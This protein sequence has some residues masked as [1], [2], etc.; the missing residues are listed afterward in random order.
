VQQCGVCN[1]AVVLLSDDAVAPSP[2]QLHNF[3]KWLPRHAGLVQSIC[4]KMPAKDYPLPWRTL[5]DMLH[6]AL[7]TVAAAA[8]AVP[9]AAALPQAAAPQPS[10][11]S[12]TLA[13]SSMTEFQHQQQ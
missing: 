6:Q 5:G 7:Q 4:A 10:T 12:T 1:I 3:V 11:V 13:S 2:L 9:S 8:A